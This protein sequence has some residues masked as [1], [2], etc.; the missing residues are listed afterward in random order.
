MILENIQMYNDVRYND[1]REFSHLMCND[2][3]TCN[4]IRFISAMFVL[5]CDEDVRS[6]YCEGVDKFGI[7]S[8][9]N[10]SWNTS[11]QIHASLVSVW[12]FHQVMAIFD[13]KISS[14]SLISLKC[15]IETCTWQMSVSIIW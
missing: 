12:L 5:L 11:N 15:I 7:T 9:D 6:G 13:A 14:V 4:F 8:Y 2:I 3:K 10:Y 1:I